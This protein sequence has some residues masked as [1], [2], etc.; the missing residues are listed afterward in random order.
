MG[1]APKLYAQNTLIFKDSV[2]Y[3]GKKDVTQNKNFYKISS[4]LNTKFLPKN[5][6][7]K[8]TIIDSNS[9]QFGYINSK[10]KFI[11]PPIYD[12][13]INDSNPNRILL[14]RYFPEIAPEQLF[15][16]IIDLQNNPIIPV[17]FTEI[18]KSNNGIIPVKTRKNLWGLYDTSGRLI[19]EPELDSI[20]FTAKKGV[21]V[22]KHGKWGLVN[23]F[24]KYSIP[25]KYKFVQPDTGDYTLATKFS[26]FDYVN[27]KSEKEFSIDCDSIINFSKGYYLYYQNEKCG[28]KNIKE[29]TKPIYSKVGKVINQKAIACKSGKWGIINHL[30]KVKLPFQ[31]DSIQI[32]HSEYIR[33][34]KNNFWGMVNGIN[35]QKIPY[36]YQQLKNYSNGMIAALGNE[37]K[38]GYLNI[39]GDTVIPFQ[40]E[41]ASDFAYGL[42]T[43]RI[44]D[45]SYIINKKGLV[46]V[47]PKD[48]PRFSQGAGTIHNNQAIQYN[49]PI[50]YYENYT[51]IANGLCLV[52]CANK[53]GILGKEAQELFPP[54]GDTVIYDKEHQV[55]I[56]HCDT[57]AGVV[58]I[59]NNYRHPLF[60]N[61]DTIHQYSQ[62]C[63]L[64]K[65]N[66]YYGG[67]DLSKNI[68][69]A[70]QYEQM[71]DYHDGKWGIT[72]QGK[73]GFIDL[74]ENIV[75]QP[76]YDDIQPFNGAAG[77]IKYKGR[78][79]LI[80]DQDKELNTTTY[81]SIAPTPFKSWVLFLDGKQGLTDT[82]GKEII[83]CRYD[84]I[85]DL[86]NGWIQV[87]KN[88]KTGIMD[89]FQNFLMPIVYDKFSFD[90][91][92]QIFIFNEKEKKVL[93]K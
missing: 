83:V 85:K 63:A 82:T 52:S 19:H 92:N 14:G 67:I 89:R 22:R 17:S 69:V 5:S 48:M 78:W 58:D 41:E 10:R 12:T 30:G 1:L 73:W 44:N 47:A 50:E 39:V 59:Y 6:I 80:S 72:L 27:I 77:G 2:L 60:Y 9:T 40:F 87:W 84:K 3:I 54:I 25:L 90:E 55:V 61:F 46:M 42:A 24:G 13:I 15:I 11:I 70:P 57:M 8:I 4:K 38:W 34:M 16:G 56:F 23:E 71:K 45:S 18:S 37:S 93:I 28:L 33:L 68:R 7:I 81:D 53:Y 31:Y 26:T 66:G 32:D 64:A 91:L 88:N 75:V 65:K 21:W 49:F 20:K 86:G 36:Q 51:K 76:N 79:N 74:N 62:N 35:F 43:V 29:D